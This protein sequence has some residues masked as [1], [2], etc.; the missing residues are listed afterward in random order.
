[1]SDLEELAPELLGVEI[2]KVNIMDHYDLTEK[3]NVRSV[4]TLVV[5]KGENNP[6]SYVGYKGK[7]DL[8]KFLKESI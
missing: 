2:K 4:P 6:S 3:Y 5:L 8:H 1:M 7:A